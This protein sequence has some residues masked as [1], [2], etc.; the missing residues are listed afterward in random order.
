MTP[1]RGD[2]KTSARGRSPVRNSA[3]P[4]RPLSQR[5]PASFPTGMASTPGTRLHTPRRR[6][7]FF[8][9]FPRHLP[10]EPDEGSNTAWAD[11][12]LQRGLEGQDTASRG[13][14]SPAPTSGTSSIVTSQGP[15]RRRSNAL[16]EV[17]ESE[18][19]LEE[20]DVAVN[21]LP[22]DKRS[23]VQD[24][25]A[26]IREPPVCSE[27]T[28]QDQLIDEQVENVGGP[29][30]ERHDFALGRPKVDGSADSDER[31]VSPTGEDSDDKKP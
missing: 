8:D 3:G 21:G 29:P 24:Q 17:P 20:D 9:Y 5:S 18:K 26:D 27:A 31:G 14:P 1:E 30:P 7:S 19:E 16:V 25:E 22:A 2:S 12:L 13:R 6:A 10:T 28:A 11:S 23:L 4:S 15:S